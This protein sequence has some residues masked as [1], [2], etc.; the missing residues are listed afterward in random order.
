M[1]ADW[2]GNRWDANEKEKWVN[3]SQRNLPNFTLNPQLLNP[4]FLDPLVSF[5][6]C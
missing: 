3:K 6:I 2:F 1:L 5:Y 4:L